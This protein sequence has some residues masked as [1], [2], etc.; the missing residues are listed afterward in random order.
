MELE[1]P[2]QPFLGARV[3]LDTAAV[4]TPYAFLGIPFGP[5]YIPEDLVVAAGAADAVRAVVDRMQYG[6]GAHHHDFD[7]A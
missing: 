4:E 5:P 2:H 1:A 3:V 7:L 6:A